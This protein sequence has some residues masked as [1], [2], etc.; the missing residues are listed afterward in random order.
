VADKV[1]S[2]EEVEAMT[3]EERREIFRAGIYWD[4][5]D[6]PPELVARIRA[7]TQALIDGAE[8]AAEG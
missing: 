4:L 5:D 3:P 1:W 2:V 6:A 7:R 8:A